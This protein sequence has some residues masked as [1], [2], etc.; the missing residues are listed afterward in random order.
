[1]PANSGAIAGTVAHRHSAPSG[2]GGDL[3][4]GITNFS[5]GNLGEVL[6]AT[7][8]DTPIWASAASTP[9]TWTAQGS[10]SGTAVS[11][12]SV[13][14]I[15]AADVYQVFYAVANPTDTGGEQTAIQFNGVTS[16]YRGSVGYANY[17]G[18]YTGLAQNTVSAGILGANGHTKTSYGQ[19]DVYPQNAAQ[20]RTSGVIY[21]GSE[22]VAAATHG[23][24]NC[25]FNGGGAVGITSAITQIDILWF[26]GS[27]ITGEMSVISMDF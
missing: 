15:T 19:I 1:M 16:G 18:A 12:L 25:A 11:S 23:F 20:G 22:S 6:T 17:S 3:T 2:D 8:T 5:G 7:A 21:R 9:S 24:D 26:N 27:N 4:E 10:D 14:G 13:T